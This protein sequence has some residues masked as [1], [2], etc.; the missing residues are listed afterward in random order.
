[1]EVGFQLTSRCRILKHTLPPTHH[2]SALRWTVYVNHTQF[3]NIQCPNT[4]K[5]PD[6]TRILNKP[7]N[8][9]STLDNPKSCKLCSSLSYLLYKLNVE[10]TKNPWWTIEDQRFKKCPSNQLFYLGDIRTPYRPI[11]STTV[12]F[13]PNFRLFWIIKTHHFSYISFVLSFKLFYSSN[14]LILKGFGLFLVSEHIFSYYKHPISIRSFFQF[15]NS[16]T[17]TKKYKLVDTVPDCSTIFVNRF[18]VNIVPRVKKFKK[19][20]K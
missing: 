19:Y 1:M 18:L 5:V 3:K 7:T 17:N 8:N 2:T 4:D 6:K 20:L 13:S 15:I 16:P 14:T 12:F 9:F 11:F 10:Q